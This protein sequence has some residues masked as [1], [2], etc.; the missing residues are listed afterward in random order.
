[1]KSKKN[2]RNTIVEYFINIQDIIK[3]PMLEIDAKLTSDY[4]HISMNDLLYTLKEVFTE[5]IISENKVLL[6]THEIKN[7]II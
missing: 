7:L 5:V 1:M 2:L 6:R 4:M 3:T